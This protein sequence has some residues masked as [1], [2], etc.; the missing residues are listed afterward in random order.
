MTFHRKIDL[1]RLQ[2]IG[3]GQL[4]V[5]LRVFDIGQD[6]QLQLVSNYVEFIHEVLGRVYENKEQ[7]VE[8]YGSVSQK[9]FLKQ[10]KKGP[11]G[12]GREGENEQ[13]KELSIEQLFSDHVSMWIVSDELVEQMKNLVERNGLE[14]KSKE[15]K[16]VLASVNYSFRKSLQSYGVQSLNN[17]QMRARDVE[18]GQKVWRMLKELAD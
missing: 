2:L 18:T 11:L 16:K 13:I 5:E 9:Q 6:E 17:L 4:R 7:L 12:I 8:F 3:E 10:A 15:I 1:S 14:E